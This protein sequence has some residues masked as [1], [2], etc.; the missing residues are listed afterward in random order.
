MTSTQQSDSVASDLPIYQGLLDELDP[1]ARATV[2]AQQ[3]EGHGTDG[4]VAEER[5]QH[6]AHQG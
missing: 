6:L 2:I 1:A 3:G 4:L 5:H